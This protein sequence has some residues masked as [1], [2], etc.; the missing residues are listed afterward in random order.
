M[1]IYFNN[2]NTISTCKPWMQQ[3]ALVEQNTPYTEY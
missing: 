3:L 2:T 1:N